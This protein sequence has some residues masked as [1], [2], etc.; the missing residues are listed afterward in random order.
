MAWKTS[1]LRCRRLSRCSTRKETFADFEVIVVDDCSTDSSATIAESF[2]ERFGGRLKI[3][4][5]PENT[6]SGAVPRNVGLDLSQGKYVY[7]VDADDLLVENA[8]EELF[9]AAEKYQADVVYMDKCF[10][11]DEKVDLEKLITI[12]FGINPIPDELTL[13][14]EHFSEHVRNFS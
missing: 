5:L 4:T 11:Y 2:L 9:N 7:F 14:T 12:T 1:R 10:F 8:L 3:V 6:G 13:E